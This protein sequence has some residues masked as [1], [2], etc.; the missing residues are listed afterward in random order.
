MAW[1]EANTHRDYYKRQKLGGL[2]RTMT[3]SVHINYYF[4]IIL[5]DGWE[6]LK[7]YTHE[8]RLYFAV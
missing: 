6:S 1:Y 8:K 2:L 3:K 7:A 4:R 5:L